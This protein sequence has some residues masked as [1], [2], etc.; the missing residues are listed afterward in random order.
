MF[1]SI[2]RWGFCNLI[3]LGRKSLTCIAIIGTINLGMG[4]RFEPAQIA[5]RIFQEPIMVAKITLVLALILILA[6]PGTVG[7]MSMNDSL[8]TLIDSPAPIERVQDC[9]AYPA[10]ERTPCNMQPNVS[11]PGACPSQGQTAATEPEQAK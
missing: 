5:D 3:R 10:D 8:P 1:I 9:T 6:C 11:S 2:V 4:A 7:V